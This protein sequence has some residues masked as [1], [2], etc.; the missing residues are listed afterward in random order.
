MHAYLQAKLSICKLSCLPYK[1][2][3][4]PVSRIVPLYL[5]N[6]NLLSALVYLQLPLTTCKQQ[7]STYRAAVVY[8]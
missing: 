3:C 7:L 6:V 1:Q 5:I 2:T 8:L 4:L